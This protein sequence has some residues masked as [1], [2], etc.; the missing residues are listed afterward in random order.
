[1][2]FGI[3]YTYIICMI[4]CSMYNAC[5]RIILKLVAIYVTYTLVD[6]CELVHVN[7]ILAR[8]CSHMQDLDII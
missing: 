5:R 6:A 7:L 8:A 1:M 4:L 2:E 3:I